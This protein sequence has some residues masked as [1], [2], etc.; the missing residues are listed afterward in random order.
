MSIPAHVPPPSGAASNHT[1]PSDGVWLRASYLNHA[2]YPNCYRA[3][4]GDMLVIRAAANLAAGTELTVAYSEANA[5]D[6]L[7]KAHGKLERWGFVCTCGLCEARNRIEEHATDEQAT[8]VRQ[9]AETF[10]DVTLLSRSAD[11]RDTS[12]MV[13]R[14]CD[15]IDAQYPA[16]AGPGLAPC[17]EIWTLT[18]PRQSSLCI[19]GRDIMAMVDGMVASLRGVG[20][21]V[22]HSR[23][24]FEIQKWG[25]LL[26]NLPE[27]LLKLHWSYERL[28]PRVCPVLHKY[29]RTAFLIMRGEDETF[30]QYF[31]S[32]ANV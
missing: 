20:F 2:C 21:V 16:Y 28:D 9:A 22:A 25:M 7:I 23:S 13:L 30:S 8:I 18:F 27:A 24:N 19:L 5:F 29:A 11:R 26:H 32:L 6:S 10:V 17:P 31:P 4:I 14:A 15:A 1:A 3:F 12:E